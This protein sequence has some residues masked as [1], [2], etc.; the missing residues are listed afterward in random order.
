MLP[1]RDRKNTDK[2]KG[3]EVA[4]LLETMVKT[5]YTTLFKRI[6]QSNECMLRELG[7]RTSLHLLCNTNELLDSNV[8]SN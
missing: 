7:D 3:S 6:S 1:L 8:M 5:N 4:D 2:I